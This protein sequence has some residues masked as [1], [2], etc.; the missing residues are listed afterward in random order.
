MKKSEHDEIVKKLRNKMNS[1]T[2][3]LKTCKHDV[4]V[5][6]RALKELL[7]K[8]VNDDRET[9]VYMKNIRN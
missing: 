1:M 5:Y 9:G 6:K 3:Q 4:K 7:K 2:Y 8:Q